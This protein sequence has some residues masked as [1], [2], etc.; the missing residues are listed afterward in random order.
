M[1]NIDDYE[2]FSGNLTTLKEASKDG[3]DG[4]NEFFMTESLLEV[5]NFDIVKNKY[6][7]NMGLKEN[8]KSNDALF[9]KKDG[10]SV[11]I[12][13]KNGYIDGKKKY[14]IKKKIYDSLL[15]F[16]D[17]I[18]KGISYTREHMD[19]IL[20]YNEQKNMDNDEEPKSRV[21]ISKHRDDIAKRFAVLGRTNHIKYGLEAF[22]KYCFSNVYTY[23]EDEFNSALNSLR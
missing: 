16:T 15:I 10:N 1:I 13:F 14:D 23:T 12:E 2:I 8:P 7:I 9:V 4:I 6:I 17:I 19:Y 18:S 20:V 11:F 22:K 3:H 21:Q 5:V